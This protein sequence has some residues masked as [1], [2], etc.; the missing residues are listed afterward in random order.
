VSSWTLAAALG[1]DP[2]MKL[3]DWL[4]NWNLSLL[5]FSLGFLDAE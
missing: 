5:K 3:R 2:G 1:Q 4:A